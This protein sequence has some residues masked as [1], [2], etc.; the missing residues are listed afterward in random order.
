M[1]VEISNAVWVYQGS[2]SS[3]LALLALA[4][5]ASPEG[6][7]WPGME[8]IAKRICLSR[9]QAQRVIHSLINEGV[10]SVIGNVYGGAPGSTRRY[11]INLQRLTGSIGAT[12]STDAAEGSHLCGDRGRTHATQTVIEP[13]LT[14][15]SCSTG[16]LMPAKQDRSMSEMMFEQFWQYYPKKVGKKK[17]Q[18]E[19][20]KCKPDAE[21]LAKMLAS[22][23]IQS[24]SVQ[25]TKE[26]R[27]FIPHPATWIHQKRWL[28]EDG[29]VKSN[30]HPAWALN[31]GF[32]NIEEAHNERCY[33][34][35]VSQFH[36]GKRIEVTA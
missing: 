30:R 19:F 3:K 11:Q 6:I 18:D 17:A 23:S 15:T 5:Y 12:G 24:Q 7:C 22:V 4:D 2:V 27:Q 26:A 16:V 29:S 21:L 10:V 34:Y 33:E 14:T 28:D 8:V 32:A 36:P 9:S 1:S 35:N 31:A 25:W 20:D 13:S